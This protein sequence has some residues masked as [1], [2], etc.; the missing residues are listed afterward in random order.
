MIISGTCGLK[1]A[2]ETL[3]VQV[4]LILTAVATLLQLF[5]LFRRI[6]ARLPVVMGISFAYVPTLTAI[7]GSLGSPRYWVR[8]LSADVGNR[9]RD[10]CQ[11]DPD[12]F[13]PLVT[14]TV[15]FTIGLSSIPLP[16]AI[17]REGALTAPGLADCAVGALP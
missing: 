9:V 11:T 7:G 4:S 15:I 8:R 16:C 10:F 14:G 5:P 2:E 13:P 12:L 3:M 6:G 1:A 17:W